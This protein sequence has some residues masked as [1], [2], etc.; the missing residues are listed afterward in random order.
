M[1]SS[2]PAPWELNNNHQ[3]M[4]PPLEEDD[5]DFKAPY[6]D[7]IDQYATPFSKT[8]QHKAYN[9]DPSAFDKG[10]SRYSL[11]HKPTHMTDSTGKDLEGSTA[12]GHDDW[13]YPPPKARENKQE[14]K[15]KRSC[16]AVVCRPDL[17][18][19]YDRRRTHR[20]RYQ[21]IP[22]SL[23]CRL[24]LLT[25]LIETTIDLA[26]ETDL[27]IRFHELGK[28]SSAQKDIVE[29]KMPVYLAIFAFAQYVHSLC[30]VRKFMSKYLTAYSNL[31]WPLMPSP[32]AT[33]FN[34]SSW[35]KRSYI[36]MCIHILL[37]MSL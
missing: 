21:L 11:D 23:A 36:A 31:H 4:R 25:V 16:M 14:K 34:S 12:H 35:R 2:H 28:I 15:E 37:T 26:I 32:R 22:D 5:E 9:V 33:P 10:A 8:S 6:D 29:R 24:Y 30:L 20:S 19:C 1:Q 3:S 17:F 13:E 27:L 18:V 7:L